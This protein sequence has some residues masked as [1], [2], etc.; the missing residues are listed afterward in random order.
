MEKISTLAELHL[1]KGEKERGREVSLARG[2]RNSK[3]I[4]EMQAAIKIN[5]NE[6]IMW[7]ILNYNRLS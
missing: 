1:E 2:K 7:T 6:K 5:E 3:G 4:T